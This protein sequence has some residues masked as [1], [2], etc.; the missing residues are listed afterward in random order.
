M[1]IQR[2]LQACMKRGNLRVSDLACWFGRPHPT[3]RGWVLKGTRPGGG[4]HDIE[5]TGQLLTLLET[6]IRTHR[7]FPLPQ[8]SPRAR[9]QRVQDIRS[10]V[11]LAPRSGG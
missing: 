11:V 5:H 10:K 2:R 3:V 4:P 8:L 6:L 9:K 1:T 7:G